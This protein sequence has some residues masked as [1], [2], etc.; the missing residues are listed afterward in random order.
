M[1][2]VIPGQA[3]VVVLAARFSRLPP[4]VDDNRSGLRHPRSA[5]SV[6][7]V[8]GRPVL[9]WSV[10]TSTGQEAPG[11]TFTSGPGASWEGSRLVVTP[12][13]GSLLGLS[14]PTHLPH[15]GGLAPRG[16]RHCGNRARPSWGMASPGKPA[17]ATGVHDTVVTTSSCS[18]ATR[19]GGVHDT[20]VTSAPLFLHSPPLGEAFGR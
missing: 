7:S 16:S 9:H 13:R 19:R 8:L 2:L 3:A 4:L 5:R 10:G 6:E 18:F 15:K 11:A 17:A 1:A 20:V 14:T 12:A